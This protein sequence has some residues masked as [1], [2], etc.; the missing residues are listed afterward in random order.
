[1]FESPQKL[2]VNTSVTQEE[3][4]EEHGPESATGKQERAG[5]EEI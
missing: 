2:S 4:C 3:A 5:E 1:M